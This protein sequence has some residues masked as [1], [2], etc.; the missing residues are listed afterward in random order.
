MTKLPD[1]ARLMGEE[2]A[3]TAEDEQVLR[4]A[5]EELVLAKHAVET[6][7]LRVE[8]VTREKEVL[9]DE[10]L[11]RVRYEVSRVSIGREVEATPEI[12]HEGDVTIIPVVEEIVVVQRRLVLKEEI[13]LTRIGTTEQ[14]RESVV[15]RHEEAIVTRLPPE[16]EREAV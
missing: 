15:L 8:T 3:T 6:G 10:P 12:R 7:R 4:L 9:V 11:E 14:H 5:A 13:H 1:S 16:A 2:P